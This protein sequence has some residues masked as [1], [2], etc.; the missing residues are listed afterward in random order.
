MEELRGAIKLESN[1]MTINYV[2]ISFHISA[3]TPSIVISFE[4]Q[5]TYLGWFQPTAHKSIHQLEQRNLKGMV[6]W[7]LS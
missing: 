5:D 4:I 2:I 3:Q 7:V 1:M 6:P